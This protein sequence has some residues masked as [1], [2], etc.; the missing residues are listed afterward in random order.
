M[1]YS[2]LR[3]EGTNGAVGRFYFSLPLI[4]WTIFGAGSSKLSS[5]P[6]DRMPVK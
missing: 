1:N 6:L 3:L 5:R 2:S 4:G